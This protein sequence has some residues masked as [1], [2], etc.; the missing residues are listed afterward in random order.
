[1][2]EHEFEPK[3]QS[4]VDNNPSPLSQNANSDKQPD[5]PICNQRKMGDNGSSNNRRRRDSKMKVQQFK[6]H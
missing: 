2:H 3:M 5:V 1:M 4:Q 6:V